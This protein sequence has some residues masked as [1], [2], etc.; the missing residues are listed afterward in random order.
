MWSYTIQVTLRAEDELKWEYV[1]APTPAEI[2]TNMIQ[3]PAN[4]DLYRSDI[5]DSIVLMGWYEAPTG[6]QVLDVFDLKYG[7]LF[8]VLTYRDPTMGSFGAF[9]AGANPITELT[10]PKHADD[11]VAVDFTPTAMAGRAFRYSVGAYTIEMTWLTEMS[12]KWE[13]IAAPAG[14]VGKSATQD[15]ANNGLY[16]CGFDVSPDVIIVGWSEAGLGGAQLVDVFDLVNNKLY[17]NFAMV[18]ANADGVVGDGSFFHGIQ[19]IVEV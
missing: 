15:V 10:M 1:D 7:R 18:H 3:N 13:Y 9:S 4:A 14:E 16:R 2:G 8:S 12:V 5:S 11:F 6:S 17:T 19:N